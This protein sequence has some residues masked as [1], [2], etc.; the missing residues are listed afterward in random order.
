MKADGLRLQQPHL[1]V[2]SG[3]LGL[4][5]Q[6]E[7]SPSKSDAVLAKNRML[8]GHVVRMPSGIDAGHP[9]QGTEPGFEIRAGGV[10][11]CVGHARVRG[12]SSQRL[13]NSWVDPPRPSP[14]L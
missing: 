6:P 7:R 8:D 4:F 5:E 11:P 10:A 12:E 13:G 9:C 1:P 2:S 14:T 3:A